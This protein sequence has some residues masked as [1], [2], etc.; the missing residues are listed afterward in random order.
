MRPL[1]TTRYEGRSDFRIALLSKVRDPIY[2][3]A[4]V[5]DSRRLLRF[6]MSKGFGLEQTF[7]NAD[8]CSDIFSGNGQTSRFSTS[9]GQSGRMRS[10]IS[11]KDF[12]KR[13]SLKAMGNLPPHRRSG[14]V[15]GFIRAGIS[16]R[17]GPKDQV[18]T[19]PASD[20]EDDPRELIATNRDLLRS[21]YRASGTD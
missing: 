19:S 13:L 8:C 20:Y 10:S 11:R 16:L 17:S 4:T 15:G 3:G 2:S 18:P 12:R 7:V 5:P 21:A 1:E 9:G 6:V 14:V